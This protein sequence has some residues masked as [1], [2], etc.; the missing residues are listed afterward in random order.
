VP[1]EVAQFPDEPTPHEIAALLRRLVELVDKP[2]RHRWMETI[3]AMVLALAT[4]GSAWCAYQ[5]N[6]W[7]GVE[8][9]RLAQ[10]A[11]MGR[12][13]VRHS[14]I[15]VQ[16]RAFDAQMLIAY[17][18]MQAQGETDVAALFLDRFRPEARKAVD[19]WL[20]TDPL[21]N[22]NAPKRPFENAAY[23]LP[24]TIEAKHCDEQAA[25]LQSAAQDAGDA[26]DRYVLLTVVFASV[27]FFGGIGGTFQS[28]R[29]KLVAFGLTVVLFV[30]TSIALVALPLC[31]E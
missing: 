19:A 3:C 13:S 24:D 14:L 12:E 11:R 17:I 28:E 22:L 30:S 6:L 27:L 26:S 16:G 2:Q 4:T 7:G 18:Q 5:A 1:P 8:T 15:A 25:G 23:V 10:S 29:L 9:N 20:K 21:H 31:R